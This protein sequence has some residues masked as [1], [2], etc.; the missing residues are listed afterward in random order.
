MS[1]NKQ[2]EMVLFGSSE[3]MSR[4]VAKTVLIRPRYVYKR[5]KVGKKWVVQKDAHDNPVIATDAAG[6]KIVATETIR[7]FPKTS[8]E[9][10]S[11]KSITGLAGQALFPFE[12]QA[13]D[14]MCDGALAEL[15]RLRASGQFTFSH[16]VRNKR[17]GAIS[18]TMKPVF[19]GKS[20]IASTDDEL[21]REME[22]RGFE[23]KKNHEAAPKSPKAP[24]TPKT[25]K[26]PKTP[27]S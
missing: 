15:Q 18:L 7:L 27:K 10:P 3:P 2:S 16:E 1:A 19:A 24:K 21:T 6:D 9:G 12:R 23:V 22:R 5:V 20:V 26:A 13:R 11:L 4:E 8:K 17:T 14:A 25:P